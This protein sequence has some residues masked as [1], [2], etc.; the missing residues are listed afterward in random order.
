MS[1]IVHADFEARTEKIQTCSPEQNQS[2]TEAY[3][4]HTDCGYV[5]KLFVFMIRNL[6]NLCR[7]KCCLQ[8]YGKDD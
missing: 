6:T 4:K 7:R 5:I 8:V 1:F 3:Q 2:H